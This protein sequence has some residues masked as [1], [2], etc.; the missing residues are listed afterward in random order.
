[1]KP[2]VKYEEFKKYEGKTFGDLEILKVMYVLNQGVFGTV[3][4]NKCGVIAVMNIEGVVKGTIRCS[5]SYKVQ[6]LYI[7]GKRVR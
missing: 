7:E 2:K 1:M 3:K 6:P 4:C 5:C